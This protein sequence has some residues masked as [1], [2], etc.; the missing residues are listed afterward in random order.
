MV[1]DGVPAFGLGLLSIGFALGTL[2]HL[3]LMVL[4]SARPAL[5]RLDR[6]FLQLFSAL[7]FWHAGNLFALIL[8]PF[9]GQRRLVLM[10]TARTLAFTGLAVIS[11]LMVD[12]HAEYAQPAWRRFVWIF[13]LPLLAGP[14]GVWAAAASPGIPRGPWTTGYILYFS[15]ALLICGWVNVKLARDSPLR[16]LH[17]SLGG[18]FWL[19]AAACVYSFL[20]ASGGTAEGIFQ[21]LLLLSSIVPS[22]LAGYWM[23]RFNFLEAAAQR[24]VVLGSLGL[25]GLLAYV[26]VIER[27]ARRLEQLGYL[28]ALVTEAAMVC[29]LVLMVEPISRRFRQWMSGQVAEQLERVEALHKVLQDAALAGSPEEFPSLAGKSLTEFFG[30]PVRVAADGELFPEPGRPLRVREAG[31][32]RGL[33]LHTREGVR[34]SK[35]FAERVRLEQELAE[36]KKMAALGQMA[37]FIAHRLKNPLS[38]M[39]TLV[40]VIAEQAPSVAGHCAV[41]RGE[42]GRL[43]TSVTDLLKFTGPDQDRRPHALIESRSAIAEAVA[44]FAADAKEKGVAIEMKVA[45]DEQLPIPRDWLHDVLVSLLGNALDAAPSGSRVLISCAGNVLAV[46]DEGSG[47]APEFR[48]RIFDPFFTQKPGGT[49]L[50]LALVRRRAQESGAEVRCH[51]PASNGRGARFEIVFPNGHNPSGG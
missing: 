20:I 48:E 8:D 44:L 51:S 19:L 5:R 3:L 6:L 2:L 27:L 36:R 37:A 42:I 38:A 47:V 39:Q 50:G 4:V 30:F 31:A 9:E 7:F 11:P 40:Q 1:L 22:A 13:Y 33:A 28:P 16:I 41:I 32:L 23:F 34:L 49:G 10:I 26:L 29:F 15:T 45:P 35:L 25:V 24:N 14:F 17:A 12:L 18:V 46:E 21:P 43:N